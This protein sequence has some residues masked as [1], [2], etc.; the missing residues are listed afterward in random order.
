MTPRA[1]VTAVLGLLLTVVLAAPAAAQTGYGEPITVSPGDSVTV[2]GEG[3]SPGADVTIEF[4]QGSVSKVLAVVTAD[5]DGDFRAVVTIP[6][7]AEPGAA[8]LVASCGG[9]VLT[10]PLHVVAAGG[11]GTLPV[12]GSS[13]TTGT[14]VGV[15][16]A[17]V[18]LG[19]AA[20]Y[21]ARRRNTAAAP[22]PAA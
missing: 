13:D 18:V 19:A 6:V 15:G 16:G 14:L 12:T 2:G 9:T 1:I 10:I 21:G 4:R 7:N 20:V 8:L 17:L 3:C 5:E 11:G 22:A